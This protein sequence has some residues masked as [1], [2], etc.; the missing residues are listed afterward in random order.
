MSTSVFAFVGALLFGCGAAAAA[1]TPH[2]SAAR[3]VLNR[4]IVDISPTPSG[5]GYW[6]VATDGGI[7][8]FGDARFVGS[9]GSIR[10]NQPIV[11]IAATPTGNGYWLAASDGGI[12]AFGDARFFGSTGGD[13]PEPTHRRHRRHTDG[14]RLLARRIRRRHLRVR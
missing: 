2:G 3:M 9:T 13:A 8:A 4:A 11:G 1:T 10:L 14:Q 7:F 12:F 5:N 6:L